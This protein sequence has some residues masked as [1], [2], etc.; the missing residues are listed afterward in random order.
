MLVVIDSSDKISGWLFAC[1][2]MPDRRPF[3]LFFAPFCGER[4]A[5]I[6]AKLDECKTVVWNG[7]LGAF[8]LK[9]FDTAT[10]IVA[11]HAAELTK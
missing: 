4:L 1:F 11:Q 2:V 9:P 3:L 7:P 8:E 6:M 5:K 10:N